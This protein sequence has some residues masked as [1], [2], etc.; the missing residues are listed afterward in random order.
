VRFVPRGRPPKSVDADASCAARLGAELRARRAARSLTLQ[1]L[2]NLAGYT[3]QHISQVELAQTRVSL[4]FVEC[5][6]R[7]LDAGGALVHLYP[8]V[9]AE[10][11]AATERRATARRN[12]R[13]AGE[14]AAR[15]ARILEQKRGADHRHEALRSVQEVDDVNRRR[16]IG[17][18]LSVVVLGPEAVAR[19]GDAEWDRIA[20]AW[21]YEIATAKDRRALLPGLAADLRRLHAYDG[22]QRVIAQLSSFAA[23]I[24]VSIDEQDKARSWWRHARQA[25]R[26][27]GDTHLQSYVAS[28]QAG[29]ALYGACSPRQVLVLADD[30]LS[31]TQAPCAGR[32][33][34]LSAKAQ[35]HAM[36][37]QPTPAT[38]TLRL[39]ERTFERLPRDI[40]REKLSALGW[41]EEKLHHTRSYCSMYGVEG[42]EAAREQALRL[43]DAAAWRGAAQVKLHRAATEKDPHYAVDVLRNLSDPQRTDQFVRRIAFNV[44]ERT[45]DAELRE[46]L[47]A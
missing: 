31:V 18:G 27:A 24:A 35:A 44:L 28:K 20:H 41:S 36:L 23:G 37:A 21:S 4:E 6:D 43:Y 3:P 25:A 1:G 22:P 9:Q 40:T 33:F 34:A 29:Q 47:H 30:A 7:A 16:F 17:L 38:E 26:S 39:M 32:M 5:V 46:V 8:A 15:N 13:R 10:R 19:A 42:G 14:E 12:E 11:M 2:S 45:D